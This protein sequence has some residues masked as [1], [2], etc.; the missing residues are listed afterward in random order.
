MMKKSVWLAALSAVW[1]EVLPLVNPS[2]EMSMSMK[3]TSLDP[4]L[5]SPHELTVKR[6]WLAAQVRVNPEVSAL[7][8]QYK[9]ASHS[10]QV[11]LLVE[12]RRRSH[13]KSLLH[14][15]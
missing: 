8:R 1:R 2:F 7:T 12:E 11:T 15:A 5:C 3:V 4:H 10:M 13:C 6:A 9:L 14:Q